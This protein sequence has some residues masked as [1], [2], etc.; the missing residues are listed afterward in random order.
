MFCPLEWGW[1]G[2]NA[3]D[4]FKFRCTKQWLN[5]DIAACVCVAG[6]PHCFAMHFNVL[7]NFVLTFG[8]KSKFHVNALLLPVHV[9]RIRILWPKK[10]KTIRTNPNKVQ[11]F[12]LF[13]RKTWEDPQTLRP[14]T[15][16]E[17]W[18]T[19]REWFYWLLARVIYAGV[20]RT[21]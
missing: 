3:N 13:K 21:Y 4:L 1:I 12:K 2:A 7:A 10:E 18:Q 6:N 11:L 17:H 15:F 9:E 20:L 16:K 14:D 8:D 5:N 19:L